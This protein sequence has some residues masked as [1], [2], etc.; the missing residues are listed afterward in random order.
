MLDYNL[1]CQGSFLYVTRSSG[2][3]ALNSTAIKGG[4]DDQFP[5]SRRLGPYLRQ[6][7]AQKAQSPAEPS[8]A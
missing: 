1:F 2:M 8:Q 4:I 7:C 6:K 5:S 3:A